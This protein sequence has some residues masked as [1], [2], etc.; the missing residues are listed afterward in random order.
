MYVCTLFATN[1]LYTLPYGQPIHMIHL[2]IPWSRECFGTSLASC[3]NCM[4]KSSSLTQVM[5]QDLQSAI[6]S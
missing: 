5:K 6:G 4:L 1:K 3:I 2:K